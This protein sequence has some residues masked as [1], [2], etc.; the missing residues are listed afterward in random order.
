MVTVSG[1]DYEA[2]REGASAFIR[3]AGRRR[4][5]DLEDV[6]VSHSGFSVVEAGPLHDATRPRWRLPSRFFGHDCE[7]RSKRTTTLSLSLV[8]LQHFVPPGE[9]VLLR[10]GRWQHSAA[11]ACAHFT[12][13]RAGLLVQRGVLRDELRNAGKVV[14]L[15]AST[16]LVIASCC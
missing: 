2:V 10:A 14:S 16:S 11:G 9:A 4:P 5:L 6:L 1:A 3:R 7:G 13:D 12:R 8:K 15:A